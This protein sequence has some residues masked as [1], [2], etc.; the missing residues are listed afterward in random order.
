[1]STMGFSSSSAIL[2]RACSV[3]LP[4]K[5]LLAPLLG[6]VPVWRHQNASTVHLGLPHPAPSPLE[7]SRLLRGLL[8]A[9]LPALFHAVATHRV[10]TFRV[11][12]TQTARRSF[13]TRSPLGLT[14]QRQAW[15]PILSEVST[16][17]LSMPLIRSSPHSTNAVRPHIE[18]IFLPPRHCY[19]VVRG[20]DSGESSRGFP[21]GRQT[22]CSATSE[23]VG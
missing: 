4:G 23:S 19:A 7:F 8:L 1:M 3:P 22:S 9:F 10:F 17:H 2:P 16:Q 18:R 6:F 12:P 14:R 13:L 20:L 11:F 5:L 21:G 15:H